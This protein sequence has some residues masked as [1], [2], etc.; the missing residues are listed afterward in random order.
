ME[1]I[2][3]HD[4]TA[5][6]LISPETGRLPEK[7]APLA[8]YISGKSGGLGEVISALCD[9]LIQRGIECHLA[10]PYLK[11][12]FQHECGL[13]E[14]SWDAIRNHFDPERIHLV[15]SSIFSNLSS[16]YAGN[17]L[18]NAAEFQKQVVNHIITTVRA[19]SQECRKAHCSQPR[20]DGGGHH[21]GLCKDPGLSGPPYGPQYPYGAHASGNV[22]RCEYGSFD[23]LSLFF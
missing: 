22:F 14:G 11:M 3:K 19:K 15:N 7:M 10:V 23:L 12:R 20:L 6:L 17:P 16:I 1:F 8:R 9:G 4:K 13:N 18:Q 21:H 2:K 5:V